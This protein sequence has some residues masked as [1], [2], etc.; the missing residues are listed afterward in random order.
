VAFSQIK[1]INGD[2]VQT[3]T[4]AMIPKTSHTVQIGLITSMAEPLVE[5]LKKEDTYTFR[6]QNHKN[7]KNR[8]IHSFS[9][10]DIDKA[11]DNLYELIMDGFEN[12][13]L[14]D[15]NNVMLELPDDII[16]LDYKK[17]VGL[18]SFR[19]KHAPKNDNKKTSF[20]AWITKEKVRKLFGKD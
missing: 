14:N 13:N 11:F 19:F 1:Q 16:W 20:S 8:K 5:C 12:P 18:V 2:A 10:K 15:K 3:D 4:T 9:F 7:S 6:Y 17:S